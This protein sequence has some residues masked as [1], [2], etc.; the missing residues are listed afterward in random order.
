[1]PLRPADIVDIATDPVAAR[2]DRRRLVVRVAVPILGVGLIVAGIL[3][4]ALYASNANRQGA[5]KLADDTLAALDGVITEKVSSYFDIPRRALAEAESLAENEPPG[6]ARRAVVE[7][8]SIGALAHI[9]QIADF[10]IADPDGNFMMIRRGESGVVDTK[11]IQN[12]PPPRRVIW[13]R[14]SATGAETGREDD[15][16]DTFDPRTR[17]WYSGA[18]A[19]SG[20]FWTDVYIFFTGKEPGITASTRYRS[21]EGRQF[22][23]GVDITLANLSEF[24]SGLKIGASGRAMIVTDQG[25]IIAYP[26]P[27]RVVQSDGSGSTA[28]VD[29]IDDAPAAAAFDR[30]R[31]YGPGRRTI[32]VDGKRYLASL[33][34]MEGI[35]HNWSLLIVVAEKDFIGFVERNVRIGLTMSLAIVLLAAIG[36]ALL[37]RQGLRGDRIMRLM[38]ARGHAIARQ[39]EALDRLADEDD[40]FDRDRGRPPDAL[41]ETAAELT[42]ARRASLWYFERNDTRLRC[43]D[44]FE[45]AQSRHSPGFEVQRGEVPHFFDRL[46]EGAAVEAADAAEDPQTAEIHRLILAPLGS[47]SLVTLPVRLHGRVVGALWLEDP[48]DTTGC[49]H[50]LR[51]LSSI[52]ALRFEAVTPAGEDH[53]VQHAISPGE[54]ARTHSRSAELAQGNLLGIDFSDALFPDVCMLVVKIDDHDSAA[55]GVKRPDFIDAVVRAVQACAADQQIPYLKLLGGDIVGAA[56]FNDSG[57]TAAERIAN[58]ALSIRE[59]LSGLFEVDELTPDFRIG[60]HR[61][62]AIGRTVGSTPSVFNLWGAAV[63]VADAMAATALPGTVQI[64]EAA[65]NELHGGFLFRP[66]GTF[67]IPDIGVARTFILAGRS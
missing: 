46:A 6:E 61:G 23:V 35:G 66:R 20:T 63:H 30:F 25:R 37:I 51:V 62:T 31:V 9:P 14:R 11:L 58:T 18:L 39:G 49:R 3:G 64:T 52:A 60:I 65:Y 57:S 42:G 38:T 26:Q 28:R 36:A 44:S 15:P 56:G 7:K 13:V 24:L 55:A 48:V 1:M 40:R 21:P 27:E 17:P 22:V 16:A 2:A 34:P 19:T 67:Y 41:T 5:L 33:A 53:H 43:V 50:F 10:I 45:P 8:F 32:T 4:I 54:P 29:Q 12:A 59:R 47:R